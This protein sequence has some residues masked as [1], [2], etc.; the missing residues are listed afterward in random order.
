MQKIVDMMRSL[1]VSYA[2]PY[3]LEIAMKFMKVWCAVA[4]EFGIEAAVLVSQITTIQMTLKPT[5]KELQGVKS[6]GDRVIKRAKEVLWEEEPERVEQAI[7]IWRV[8]HDWQIRQEMAGLGGCEK[9]TFKELLT[10]LKTPV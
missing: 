1:L 7:D 3:D 9:K 8:S 10:K 2:L 6:F 4:D 5:M